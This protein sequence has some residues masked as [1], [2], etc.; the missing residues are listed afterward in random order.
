MLLE[1]YE[2]SEIFSVTSNEVSNCENDVGDD[3]LDDFEYIEDEWDCDYSFD[4]DD[5]D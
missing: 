4:D 3:N 2:V 5:D 1:E